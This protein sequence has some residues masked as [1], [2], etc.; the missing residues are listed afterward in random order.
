[1]SVC[2][3]VSQGS[4]RAPVAARSATRAA[5]AK[6]LPPE[7]PM[8]TVTCAEESE[9]PGELRRRERPSAERK[10]MA[11]RLTHFKTE[12]VVCGAAIVAH[13]LLRKAR[14]LARQRLRGPA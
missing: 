13:A 1:M 14:D 11:N 8:P 5:K 3:V 2:R 4:A 10:L 9:T 6:A 7:R 12:L